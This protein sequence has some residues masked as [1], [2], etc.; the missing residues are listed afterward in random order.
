VP[1]ILNNFFRCHIQVVSLYDR[2]PSAM[3]QRGFGALLMLAFMMIMGAV[4]FG[5]MLYNPRGA[6]GARVDDAKT[7]RALATAKAALIGYAVRRGDL[8]GTTRPGELP[9]PD[10]NNDGLEE[11]TC[12]AGAIG[13]IPWRTLGIPAPVDS[14]G[15]VLWYAVAGPLRT[16]PSNTNDVNS[17][18]RGNL[19]VFA[20]DAR[21]SITSQ[22]MPK[23]RLISN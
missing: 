1:G 20:S 5:L 21:S 8:A 4:S 22:I 16:Q 2:T 15:E 14:S 6:S 23:N 7:E 11:A 12:T 3:S 19:T 13:R 10:T 18:T 9:C 17:N